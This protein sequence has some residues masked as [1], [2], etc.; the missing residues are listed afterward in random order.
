MKHRPNI[1]LVDDDPSNRDVLWEILREEPYRLVQAATGQAA[2]D[3]IQQSTSAFDVIVLDRMMPGMDGLEIMARLKQNE[4]FRWIPVIMAT[5]A[6]TPE[7]ICEGME[8]GVF[9]YLIKPFEADTLV[10]MVR[11]ALDDRQKWQG[12]RQS[13]IAPVYSVQFLQSGQFYIRTMEEAYSLAIFLAQACEESERVAFG[14]NEILCNAVEHG[15]LGIGFDEKTR[16]QA[17]D[18]W[19]NEIERRLALPENMSKTVAVQFERGQETLA[20]TIT[21]QGAGFNWQKYEM[22]HPERGFE[23]H[24]RGIAMAKALSFQKMEYQGQGNQVRCLVTLKPY[25]LVQ[26]GIPNANA[27]DQE[28]GRR[29]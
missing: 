21:D 10:R 19:E 28:Q 4:K 14:L 26:A 9:F 7:E 3:I 16:L 1:L 22:L 23:S 25:R 20:L 24:G 18:I 29:S 15:N 2:L 27:G 17:H 5:A 13:L 12:I 8:A 11:A 6:G